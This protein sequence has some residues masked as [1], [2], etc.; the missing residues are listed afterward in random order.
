MNY[1]SAYKC[2]ASGDKSPD[3][4][5]KWAGL[6]TISSMI[7]RRIWLDQGRDRTYANLYCL[8][9]GPA[10]NGKSTAMKTAMKLVKQFREAAPQLPGSQTWQSCVK[11]LA[12]EKLHGRKFNYNSKDVKYTHGSLFC[13]E[14]AGLLQNDPKGWITFLTQIYGCDDFD[15]KVKTGGEDGNRYDLIENPYIVFL[16]CMTPDVTKEVVRDGI[17]SSGFNR[18]C[19][20]VQHGRSGKCVP[21]RTIT[22]EQEQARDHCMKWLTKLA[23]QRGPF[24]FGPNALEFFE[25]WYYKNHERLMNEPVNFM[26]SWLDCKDQIILKVAMLLEMGDNTTRQLSVNSLREAIQL[27]DETEANFHRIFS[28]SGRN[29]IHEI[30]VKIRNIIEGVKDP[31][32]SKKIYRQLAADGSQKEIQEAIAMLLSDGAIESRIINN[33]PQPMVTLLG[34]PGQWE[35]DSGPAVGSAVPPTSSPPSGSSQFGF[36]VGPPE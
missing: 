34:R 15:H 13:D 2:W 32:N 7:S 25:Q 31:V 35:E 6:S 28:M 19:I 1:L 20:F 12:D 24:C 18:R 9:V 23:T 26:A 36:E 29:P 5:H 3:I 14:F 10:G 16:G 4:Y 30:S 33:P 21:M 17:I 11:D 22:A 27:V 8:F